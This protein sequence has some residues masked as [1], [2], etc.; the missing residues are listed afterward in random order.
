L[1]AAAAAAWAVGCTGPNPRFHVRSGQTDGAADPLDLGAQ[2]A[3][4][5]HPADGPPMSNDGPPT[6]NDTMTAPVDLGS[7][8]DPPITDADPPPPDTT[9]IDLRPPA[10]DTTTPPPPDVAPE[11]APP[12]DPR[13]TSGLSAYWAF[14]APPA[15]G[16]NTFTDKSGSVATLTSITWTVVNDHAPGQPDGSRAA[17][18]DGTKGYIT[19]AM[20][21]MPPPASSK[22]IA[23]W[24]RIAT[25]GTGITD[26]VSIYD[27]RL[28]MNNGV[29]VGL[30]AAKLAAWRFGANPELT[31]PAALPSNTWHH[32]AYTYEAGLHIL[33]QDGVEVMRKANIPIGG[34]RT[35]RVFIGTYVE[36]GKPPTELFKGT[37][38]DVRIYDHALTAPEVMTLAHPPTP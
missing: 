16:G 15:S 32:A 7:M 13:P 4:G 20:N 2:G 6:S 19:V 38:S 33:Y 3:G 5:S 22:T 1:F 28:I 12:V 18:F 24:V 21:P 35:D 8:V 31:A 23:L 17:V 14:N 27:S 29:Q 10:P 37:L 11:A 34:D 26:L 25:P 30:T 36:N 9:P